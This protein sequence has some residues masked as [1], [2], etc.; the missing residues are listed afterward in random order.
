MEDLLR[1]STARDEPFQALRTYLS[2]Q[3]LGHTEYRS[4]LMNTPGSIRRPDRRLEGTYVLAIRLFRRLLLPCHLKKL[5]PVWQLAADPG[6]ELS[7]TAGAVFASHVDRSSSACYHSHN[8][9][10]TLFACVCISN[11]ILQF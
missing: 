5:C 6:S 4:S 7:A 1:P 2:G 10:S 8:T 9:V 11:T 3:S